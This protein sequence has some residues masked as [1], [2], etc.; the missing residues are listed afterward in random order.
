MPEI[1]VLLK[2]VPDTYAYPIIDGD[3]VEWADDVEWVRD[4]FS[5]FAVEEAVKTKEAVGGNITSY[6]ITTV[7][8]KKP[9]M[10]SL[11][12]GVDN[13]VVI[14]NEE[15]FKSDV[16]SLARALGEEIKK[17]NPDILFAGK[18]SSDSNNRMV[19][20]AVAAYLDIP[21]IAD[22]TKLEVSETG[23]VATR[24]IGTRKEIIEAEFPVMIITD[25]L[26]EPRY[27]KLPDLMKAKRK[28]MEWKDT[29]LTEA[30]N[31]AKVTNLAEPQKKEGE[32]VMINDGDMAE[33][34]AKLLELL[35]DTENVL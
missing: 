19:G 17:Q 9:M 21:I 1:A 7:D 27:P 22:V 16:Y 30:R 26:N 2:V 4:R 5:Q 20:N 25:K 11:A 6:T 14:Q 34:V 28:P 12:I 23:V 3:R 32:V 18:Y 8:N 15:L 24:K 33:R 10:K 29:A 31:A 13:S 35:K